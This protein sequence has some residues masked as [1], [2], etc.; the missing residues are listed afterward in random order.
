MTSADKVKPVSF[1]QRSLLESWHTQKG[2]VV[3]A[4]VVMNSKQKGS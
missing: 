3:V 4:V 1:V 2:I